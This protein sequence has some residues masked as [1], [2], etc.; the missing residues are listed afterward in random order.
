MKETGL[1]SNISKDTGELNTPWMDYMYI[2]RPNADKINI[3]SA[4]AIFCNTKAVVTGNCSN[5][6]R[7]NDWVIKDNFIFRKSEP[8]L[9]FD[10]SS[11][12]N[13]FI[14]FIEQEKD[15]AELKGKLQEIYLTNNK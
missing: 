4:K 14:M 5:I 2:C 3:K 12:Y 8:N 6:I 1:Y 7:A 13:S 9:K 15:V 11:R 10:I